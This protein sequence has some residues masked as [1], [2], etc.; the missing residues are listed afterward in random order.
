MQERYEIQELSYSVYDTL[1]PNTSNIA[2]GR[3]SR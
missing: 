1:A 2:I 3:V